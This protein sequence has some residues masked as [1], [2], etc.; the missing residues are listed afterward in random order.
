VASLSVN[1]SKHRCSLKCR[2]GTTSVQLTGEICCLDQELSNATASIYEIFALL[3]C[4][5]HNPKVVS[6]NLTPATT[7]RLRGKTL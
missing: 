5:A 1:G 4:E 7:G 3:F 6:S 2:L